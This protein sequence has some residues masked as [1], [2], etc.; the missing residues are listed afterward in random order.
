MLSNAR[1]EKL[2]SNDV[3][4]ILGSIILVSVFAAIATELY[5]LIVLPLFVVGAWITIADYKKLFYLLFISIPI[6]ID[7]DLPGGLALN[8]FTEPLQILLTGIVILLLIQQGKN[9]SK[10]YLTHPITIALLMHMAW[11]V[12][13]VLY[14]SDVL[15]SV[16]YL[17]A[18]IWFVLPAFFLTMKLVRNTEDVKTIMWCILLPLLFTISVILVRHAAIGFSFDGVNYILG[19]FY[20]NHVLYASMIAIMFPFIWFMRRWYPT[21]S[22]KWWFL[23]F[24]FVVMMVGIYL[25]YTRATMASV[26]IVF[27]MYYIVKWRLSK[28]AFILGIAT[29]FSLFFWLGH[30]NNFMNYTPNFE[31]TITHQR[32]DNLL[33]ATLKGQDISIAER[34]YR[35]IAGLYMVGE[36]PVF[37]YGPSSFYSQ[38]KSY[39][40]TSFQTYVSGNEE[41]SGIHNYFLMILVEQ[42]IPGLF[43]FLLFSFV[44]FA[45]GEEIYHRQ[46][47]LASR[48]I[49]M[50]SILSLSII[51]SLL[52]IN[53]MVEADKIG[54]IYFF[55]AGLLVK[56]DLL[57]QKEKDL[58]PLNT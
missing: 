28:P 19:P 2:D 11:I 56:F 3:F 43:F 47:D 36:E 35:W 20:S 34:Y 31:R 13:A 22:F 53:D 23:S 26:F 16:K 5:F 57:A 48:N 50:A 32:F 21:F 6:S 37:G 27:G 33:E 10:K 40:L 25:S 1:I 9:I 4:W 51:Y 45:K 15:V 49:V 38:Y 46:H 12:I 17:L 42:G 44:L 54:V 58:K 7:L 52:V 55:C 29:L 18:K 14:S 24:S 8:F 30:R 41:R 39:T